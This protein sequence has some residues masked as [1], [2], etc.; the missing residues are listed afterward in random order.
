MR[1]QIILKK[2]LGSIKID[3]SG[4]SLIIYIIGSA[5]S[6]SKNEAGITGNIIQLYYT[7]IGN[8]IHILGNVNN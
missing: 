2:N 7:V 5:P 4:A 8:N 3:V 1:Y 6:T